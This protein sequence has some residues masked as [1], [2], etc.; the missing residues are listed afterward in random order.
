MN[1]YSCIRNGRE[2]AILLGESL[3]MATLIT[4]DIVRVLGTGRPHIDINDTLDP[5]I[6]TF[7]SNDAKVVLYVNEIRVESLDSDGTYVL[8]SQVAA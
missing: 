3:D 8:K 7:D 4:K 1:L 6:L 2:V 5:I